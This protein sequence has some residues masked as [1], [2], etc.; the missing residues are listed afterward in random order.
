[1]ED[2][3]IV[4]RRS[5]NGGSDHSTELEIVTSI[6]AQLSR[7]EPETRER[8]LNTVATFYGVGIKAT[9]S[10]SRTQPNAPAP[11]GSSAVSFSEDRSISPKQFMFEKQPR[12]DVEKVACLAYYLTHYRDTPHFKTLDISKL[13]TEAAQVKFSNATVA[14][15]N[16]S[17]NNYLVPATKG[18]KQLSALGEQFV[19]A[20]PDRERAKAIMA[21]ARPRRKARRVEDE[22]QAENQAS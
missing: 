8:I 18:N 4:E 19:Q 5:A 1:V 12:T 20:L 3:V 14:V 6:L 15:D 7:T 11:S 13:N 22:A 9:Q 16:A 21:S 2:S 17:K 10:P